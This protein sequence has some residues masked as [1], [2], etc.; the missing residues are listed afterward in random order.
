VTIGCAT[1]EEV[2]VWRELLADLEPSERA[3]IVALA[4]WM[5]DHPEEFAVMNLADNTDDGTRQAPEA[6]TV[7]IGAFPGL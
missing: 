6:G 3:R 7:A 2:Q 4:V 1:R 5:L